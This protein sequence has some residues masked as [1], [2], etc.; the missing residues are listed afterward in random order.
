MWSASQAGLMALQASDLADK[1]EPPAFN[2]SNVL[3]RAVKG[4]VV[5]RAEWCVKHEDNNALI[6]PL[7]TQLTGAVFA[8]RLA[9]Y[10]CGRIGE[11]GRD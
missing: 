8:I 7:S 5:S 4:C 11:A 9:F 6:H 10:L 2:G 1:P 3:P